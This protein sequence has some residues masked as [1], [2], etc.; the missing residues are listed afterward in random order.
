MPSFE[1]QPCL[2]TIWRH[3]TQCSYLLHSNPI[4]D[5]YALWSCSIS[6]FNASRLLCFLGILRSLLCSVRP[7]QFLKAYSYFK[8]ELVRLSVTPCSDIAH[9]CIQCPG[10]DSSTHSSLVNVWS[11]Y[12]EAWSDLKVL[13]LLWSHS[14]SLLSIKYVYKSMNVKFFNAD[15]SFTQFFTDSK[16]GRAD[17]CCCT[18]GVNVDGAFTE[19]SSSENIPIWHCD[20]RCPTNSALV[21]APAL[22]RNSLHSDFKSA[23]LWS[24]IGSSIAVSCLRTPRSEAAL[25]AISSFAEISSLNAIFVTTEFLPTTICDVIMKKVYS[26]LSSKSTTSRWWRSTL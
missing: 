26:S 23:T 7:T 12:E 17:S 9:R 11:T 10:L 16:G 13:R 24:R 8:D 1:R 14:L 19:P 6:P 21:A 4:R 25:S 2:L 22:M 18:A 20:E 3:Q 5:R 15:K